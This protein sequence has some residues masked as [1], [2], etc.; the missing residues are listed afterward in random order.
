ME[1]SVKIHADA[2]NFHTAFCAENVTNKPGYDTGNR[3]REFPVR[4]PRTRIVLGMGIY[5]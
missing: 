1:I 2:M 3:L 4:N 5:I